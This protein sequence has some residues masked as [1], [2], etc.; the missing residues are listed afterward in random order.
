VHGCVPGDLCQ[1]ANLNT[2][3]TFG[4]GDERFIITDRADGSHLVDI[5]GQFGVD[6]TGQIWEFT[7][8]YSYR[9]PVWN[10]GGGGV[11]RAEEWFVG[12][13]GSLSGMD[14]TGCC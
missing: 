7:N 12:G 8:G 1:P 11:F 3:F 14:P 10:S 5:Y 4:L 9:L 2:P 13:V 6:G